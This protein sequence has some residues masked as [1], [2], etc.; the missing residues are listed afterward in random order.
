MIVTRERDVLH[1][2]LSLYDKDFFIH[3]PTKSLSK[4]YIAREDATPFSGKGSGVLLLLQNTY[5]NPTRRLYLPKPTSLRWLWLFLV[6]K[7]MV[8][9]PISFENSA[10]IGAVDSK[11][12]SADVDLE[13][14]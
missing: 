1:I 10:S 8:V 12:S 14:S 7:W 3:M 4:P 2:R 6:I 5:H 11:L 13:V 9:A